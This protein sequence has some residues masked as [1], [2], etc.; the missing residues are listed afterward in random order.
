MSNWNRARSECTSGTSGCSQD[1]LNL[2]PAANEDALWST[3]GFVGGAAGLVG[4]A[5]LWATAP[6][7]KGPGHVAC[8]VAPVVGGDRVGLEMVGRF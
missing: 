5:L 8:A 4:G 2:Q 7:A 1:A 3:V 6:G